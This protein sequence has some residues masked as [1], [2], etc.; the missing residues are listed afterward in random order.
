MWRLIISEL[1]SK[2]MY[3]GQR[4]VFMGTIKAQVKAIYIRGQKVNSA[5]FGASTKPIFRSESARYV[6]FIQMSK[7]MWDF[8]T[9]GTGEIMFNK[10]INGFLPELFK[11]WEDLGARHLVSII[12]FTRLEYDRNIANG[13]KPPDIG[14]QD[15]SM[16]T[17]VDDTPYKDF[18]RVLVSDLSSNIWAAILE[19]LKRE[20]KTFLRDVSIRRTGVKK[21]GSSLSGVHSVVS[22][23]SQAV[24]AGRPTAAT[25]GNILEA[26]NLA[27]SQFSNDYIDRDL[28]RTGLSIIVITPGTGVFEVDHNMLTMTTDVLIENGIG[29]DLVCLS[30]MPLHSVP[31]FKYWQINT[32]AHT[33]SGK[34]TTQPR[35][36]L[37]TAGSLHSLASNLTLSD[38]SISGTSP[39]KNAAQFERHSSPQWH[40]G[41]PHWVDVSFW[42]GSSDHSNQD[43]T[44]SNG[45][46]RKRTAT[47]KGVMF[48]PRVR[49]YELQMMGVMENEMS[50]ISIPPLRQYSSS[51]T[52]QK[53]S[54]MPKHQALSLSTRRSS[55]LDY[56]TDEVSHNAT[57][58]AQ[59]TSASPSQE[60]LLHEHE[61][62][63]QWM[64]EY[65]KTVFSYPWQRQQAKRQA[66]KLE[67]ARL[68]T[69]APYTLSYGAG[70]STS[71]SLHDLSN[72]GN[73]LNRRQ[74][75]LDMKM[76][77]GQRDQPS[78][79]RKSSTTSVIL[80]DRSTRSGPKKL[81]RHISFGLRGLG[82]PPK[83]VAST[84]IS[85]EHAKSASLLT[86]GL[87]SEKSSKGDDKTSTMVSEAESLHRS[88][89]EVDEP[90]PDEAS[91]VSKS[92]LVH[93][94]SRPIA[95]IRGLTADLSD[96]NEIG[97]RATFAISDNP[98]A[99]RGDVLPHEVL[100]Q[101]S[102]AIAPNDPVAL[103]PRSAIGPWLTILNP[104]NPRKMDANLA[105][106]LGRWHHV[107]PRPLRA[108][109]IK[110][111][112]LCSPASVPLTTEDFPSADQLAVEY[113]ESSY[114]TSQHKA[115][116][117]SEQ[118][119]TSDRL[120]RELI[121]CRL[122]HGFQIV[123]GPRLGRTMGDPSLEHAEIFDDEYND[124]NRIYLSRG[125]TIHELAV[126]EGGK[127]IQIKCYIR[128]PMAIFQQS[129]KNS[130]SILYTP[131][132]RTTLGEGYDTREFVIGGPR[133]TYD[134][135]RVDHFLAGHEEQQDDTGG[136]AS[137]F[138]QARFVLIPVNPPVNAR[139][140][141]QSLKP[142]NEDTDEE[143]RLEGIRR[144]SI[145]FQRHRYTN[146]NEPRSQALAR[147]RKDTNPL[148]IMYQT[149]SPSQVV[150]AE[151]DN[152]L[153][154]EN[155]SS[156]R[157]SK[158]LPEND[159]FEKAGLD[160]PSLAQTI[161]GDHGIRMMDRRW[162]WRLHYNCFVGLE[163]A[164]WLLNN[165]IDVETRDDAVELG[166][167]LMKAGLFQHVEGRHA[168][169][170][171][172]YF[173]Q[174]ASEYRILRSESKTGWF[175]TRRPDAS[176]P[177]TPGAEGMRESPRR[178][179]PSSN[180]DHNGIL[181]NATPTLSGKAN[182]RV[183]LSKKLVY[184]VDHRKR[185]YRKELV[186]LHYDRV[187]QADDAYHIRIDWLNV[188]PKLIEDAIVS[189]ATSASR[190]GL[191]LVELP[192]GEASKINEVHPFRAPKLVK[193]ARNPPE[194]EPKNYFESTSLAPRAKSAFPYQQAILRRFNFVLDL[195][196]AKDFP[197]NV[198]VSYSWGK[199]DY[200]FPQF[201]SRSGVLLAQITDEGDFLLLANRL[202]NNRSAAAGTEN[203]GTQNVR[204]S[205]HRSPARGPASANAHVSS[206]G[207]SPFSSPMIRATPDVGPGL[208]RSDWITP[209]KITNE[210]EAFCEDVEA[211]EKFFD[212][213][214]SKNVASDPYTPV[215]EDSNSSL[216]VPPVLNLRE[217][218][219]SRNTAG[220][221]SVRNKVA[222]N[223]S[224]RG[225][226]PNTQR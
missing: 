77:G 51:M 167:E 204:F 194:A 93:K 109:V 78:L 86:R 105:S 110:W 40:Y 195:E 26:I 179:R 34:D 197:A 119:K 143:I 177:S 185:S 57:D 148:D 166:N 4:L 225:A 16:R 102:D 64:D 25:R 203:N 198:D 89:S 10:V 104:S 47:Y 153:L 178:T 97:N 149:R 121:F 82:G 171:G 103:S 117:L 222:S 113:L 106:R 114:C 5:F 18:Y 79:S 214:Q 15:P 111:K 156:V 218:S 133:H 140:P 168:F 126:V 186:N 170:D 161:Q 61:A 138:W 62:L 7:E 136:D 71:P 32:Q 183:S 115:D 123:V 193:L 158:L 155:E 30:R 205:A 159:L 92:S 129:S 108:S 190:F 223:G 19:Q 217:I 65:D 28:V 118:P 85:A 74:G 202:Y 14:T 24:I 182:L 154:T 94:P 191:R 80:S 17:S 169:R 199:P 141:L 91:Q 38:T 11:R 152:A 100:D 219:P 175:G 27:S 87:K 12:L 172:N 46:V 48:V 180:T 68:K 41:I 107:F 95:I 55:L 189:W 99:H 211:L 63:F 164:T 66:R 54:T 72:Y 151:V 163:F 9:D 35:V 1:A 132:V 84:E 188:T 75:F 116:D 221:N 147:K 101:I 207:G 174:I 13:F 201:I 58:S 43:Q 90:E 206:P 56:G 196:A 173:Y 3:K 165:F 37:E 135:H 31:L 42:T 20:F 144:L 137:R 125:G 213:V 184:D 53:P 22:G 216:A 8:D 52:S 212:E 146:P 59:S 200:Q 134:W 83:A 69:T 128:R 98:L 127:S 215:M 142:L 209:E 70:L 130:S 73:P 139:R 145:L 157:P 45:T 192:I 181:D 33:P 44:H 96:A 67:L 50:N 187:A 81:A 224:P 39:Q 23:D 2:S 220:D 162:H 210:L 21:Q 208:A 176:V 88:S 76:Q 160:I 6:L 49:M 226:S 60:T 112:S 131:A 122:S 150:A 124:R 120:I 36:K 29:I